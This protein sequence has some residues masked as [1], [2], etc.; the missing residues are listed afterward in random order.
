MLKN[1]QYLTFEP[2]SN[3]PTFLFGLIAA[4]K[5]KLNH[6]QSLE[7]HFRNISDARSELQSVSNRL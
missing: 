1:L 5:V 3:K 2:F 7:M 6:W 4:V